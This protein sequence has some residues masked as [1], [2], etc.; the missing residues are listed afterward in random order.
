MCWKPAEQYGVR[1]NTPKV[2]F[3][4]Y[5]LSH[6]DDNDEKSLYPHYTT[7]LFCFLANFHEQYFK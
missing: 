1:K 5:T 2:R 7:W 3:K 6:D 4:R